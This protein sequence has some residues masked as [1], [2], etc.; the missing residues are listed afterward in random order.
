MGLKWDIGNADG[1][2]YAH[3]GTERHMPR[4]AVRMLLW[5]MQKV[6]EVLVKQHGSKCT[7]VVVSCVLYACN[8]VLSVSVDIV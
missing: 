1:N 8:F 6:Q 3:V 5:R 2:L 4:S 7:P